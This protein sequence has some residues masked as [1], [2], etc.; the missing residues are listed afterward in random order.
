MFAGFAV[1]ERYGCDLCRRT[2]QQVKTAMCVETP[3]L[4]RADPS[5][6]YIDGK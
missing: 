3:S 1:V 5:I 6:I 2:I 4:G